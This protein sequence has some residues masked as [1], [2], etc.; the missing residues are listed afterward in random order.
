MTDLAFKLERTRRRGISSADYIPL[1]SLLTPEVV[2]MRSQKAYLST[3]QLDGVCVET[4]EPAIVSQRK[5]ALVQF[6]RSLGGGH[7]SLWVHR[8]RHPCSLI[9]DA[10]FASPFCQTLHDKYTHRLNERQQ[11]ANAL[12]LSIVYCPSRLSGLRLPS[13]PSSEQR[14]DA[15]SV[16]SA[17]NDQVEASLQPYMPRRLSLKGSDRAPQSELLTLFGRLLNGVYEPIGLPHA[18]ISAWLPSS[19]LHF[20]RYSSD[21]EIWHPLEH[22]FAGMLDIQ[23]FPRTSEP[24]LLNPLLYV[25]YDYVETQSFSILNRR[26]A[27]SALLRQKGRLIATDDAA[28]EEVGQMDQAM[29]DLQSGKLELGEYHYSLAVFGESPKRVARHLADAR[30]RLQDA[31]GLR[32]SPVDLVP[33]CAWFSQLPGNWRLRPR[34]ALITSRNFADLAGFHNFT[35]G[36][37]SGNPWGQAL[38]VFDTPSGHPYY[39][40]FH[41]S[42]PDQKAQGEPYP[43]NTFICGATGVGKTALQSFLLAQS[44][45]YEGLRA[46]IFD[47][48]RGAELFIRASGGRYFQL[49]SGRPTGFN[50]F[51]LPPTQT[52]LRFCQGL[53]MTLVSGGDGAARLTSSEEALLAHAVSA[54]MNA[55]VDTSLRSLSLVAQNLP[56]AGADSLHE[57]LRKWLRGE[58][59]GWVFDNAADLHDPASVQLSGFDYTDILDDPEIRTPVMAYLLHRTEEMID[60]RPFIYVMEEFWKPLRDPYFADFALNKQKTIRK[61]GGLG[62]FVTQSPSDVLAHPIGKTMVEQSVTQIFLPNP[63]ADAE[64]YVDGFKLTP[65]EF[66]I[67]RSFGETSRKC[68]IRQGQT[69]RVVSY[70]LSGLGEILDIL[71]GT[72]RSVEW[73]DAIRGEVGDDPAAWLPAFYEALRT[74]KRQ[75]EG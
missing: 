75:V 45:K 41:D 42:P 53:L 11:R 43:G 24:G 28:F 15:L 65:T 21:V 72:T 59:L 61:Q 35:E 14:N 5:E 67:L 34:S 47:K 16:M 12:Y 73:L 23:D 19:R 74:K 71:A 52:N 1:T 37:A 62:V 48:D 30:A 2:W 50:P 70:D 36:K 18:D 33:E 46:V 13:L 8:L 27:L 57:R 10:Q 3:W 56:R 44:T 68:L 7:Y 58:R 55:G 26:D 20:A 25:D 38:A 60:G 63:R 29:N 9:L 54:V 66:Q 69:S 31:A 51:Q 40:N 49:I 39:F 6:L 22:R 17:L 32:L 4:A 64:D